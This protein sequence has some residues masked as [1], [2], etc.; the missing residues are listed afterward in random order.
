MIGC[1][2]VDQPMR[3]SVAPDCCEVQKSCTRLLNESGACCTCGACGQ[4]CWGGI[5]TLL[6]VTGRL[7]CTTALSFWVKLLAL[8][9]SHR[10]SNKR[11]S[12]YNIQ[13]QCL[14]IT[15]IY[16]VWEKGGA[17]GNTIPN[18]IKKICTD[19]HLSDLP[20]LKI[21]SVQVHRKKQKIQK[22]LLLFY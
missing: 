14:I 17:A 16:G 11:P 21:I 22:L 19:L 20:I 3:K 6:Q 15:G 7:V 12:S 9:Y 1:F 18:T 13:E 4:G 8:Q 5:Y 2:T 10:G